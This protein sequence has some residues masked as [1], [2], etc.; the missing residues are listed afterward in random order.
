M[1][2][3]I[4]AF[5]FVLPVL[6]VVVQAQEIERP[7]FGSRLNPLGE[8][9]IAGSP[10]PGVLSL[11]LRDVV[12][13]ALKNNLA[14]LLG[15]RAEQ[16]AAAKRAQDRGDY[17]PKIEAYLAGEQR[18]VNLAAFGFGGFPGVNQIIGPFGLFDA[19]ATFSQSI[20]D[21]ERRHNLQGS[22]ESQRAA[23][24]TN[25]D[26]REMVALTAVDLYFQVV[27]SQSRVTATEAQLIRA[28]ALH[29]HAQDL[30]SAG[31][32]PGIDVLRAE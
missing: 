25:A 15:S 20:V 22:T 1:V 23:T 14:T 9:V 16:I 21:F 10:S 17:F 27:S 19:R 24:F 28:K 26:I 6:T 29:D 7:A 3:R 11:G 18:Q 8:S 13:R 5:A 4:F 12:D 30:K 32:V 31:V 2:R